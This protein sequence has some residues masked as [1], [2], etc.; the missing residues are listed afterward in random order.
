MTGGL[1][2]GRGRVAISAVLAAMTLVVL[3]AGI[4]NVAL[5]NLA[6]ALQAAPAE[7]V[8]IVTAYQT[9]LV[10]ALLPCA[11]LGERFGDRRVFSSG[12]ALFTVASA[13]CA[14]SPSLP[15]LLAARFVQGLGG[16]AVMAL[17]IALLRVCVPSSK[18]GAAI[19]W[20]ALTVALASAAAPSLGAVILSVAEWPWLWA[21]NLPIGVAALLAGRALPRSEGTG[22]RLDL[23]SIGLNGLVFGGL[24][25]GAERLPTAPGQA[26]TLLAVSALGLA[27]LVRRELPKTAPLI[28]LDLLRGRAFR[29]SVIASVCCFTGQA[30]ALVALPFHL[31]HGL[32]Q[33]PLTAGL[34][35]TPWP[36][37]VALTATLAGRLADRVS[38]T[39]L[40]AMGGGCLAL[41]LAAAALAPLRADPGLLVPITVLCG[42]GFGLFQTPNNRNMF[43]AAPLSRSGAAGGLQ[44]TAR[45][46]G[47][48]AGAL[49]MTLL[50]SLTSTMAAPR[51]GLGI[52]AVMAL[53][54]GLVSLLR[55]PEG[56]PPPRPDFARRR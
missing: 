37:C 52:G 22:T 11:A 2:T 30:A 8:L 44:A 40:C 5:P 9:A 1:P 18:L 24:V 53:L 13:A 48:T 33:T 39:R 36:L 43:L 49:V 14:L 46:T 50:F 20:N 55:L 51:I 4:V 35:M 6:R 41:G 56:R 47:Q 23:R 7:A 32:G 15:W 27:V 28:P 34:Y 42:L 17:G 31:Q 19:G 21:I 10:M 45:L 26:L 3:D 25:V 12:V 38:T 16:A 54:A 29:L